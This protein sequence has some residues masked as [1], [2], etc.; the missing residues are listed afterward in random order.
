MEIT[1]YFNSR[2]TISCLRRMCLFFPLN[3]LFFAIDIPAWQS[4]C[5][6]IEGVDCI[7]K[8]IHDRKFLNHSTSLPT[9]SR[10]INSISMVE[11]A[12]RVCLD[13]F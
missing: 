12:I 2:F 8:G 9:N 7:S 11:V 13:D 1:Q 5:I 3:V 10:A 6:D 4:Q